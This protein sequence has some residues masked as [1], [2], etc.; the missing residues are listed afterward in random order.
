MDVFLGATA[1][2]GKMFAVYVPARTMG[3]SNVPSGLIGADAA[4]TREAPPERVTR[5][6]TP[7]VL[8]RP[9][10]RPLTLTHGGGEDTPSVNVIGGTAVPATVS[11]LES[12]S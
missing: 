7:G 5:G 1:E 3:N 12:R 8:E 9:V 2:V 6:A 11:G 4:S 10:T